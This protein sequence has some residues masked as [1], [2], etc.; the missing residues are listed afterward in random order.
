APY[1]TVQIQFA[2]LKTFINTSGSPNDYYLKV[3]SSAWPTHE[4]SIT[5]ATPTLTVSSANIVRGDTVTFTVEDAPGGTVS[6]WSY[7]VTDPV[8]WAPIARTTNVGDLT[9]TGPLAVSG[10]ANVTVA[11]GVHTAQLQ[12]H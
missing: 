5:V 9:W 2:P 7:Q 1:G 8:G 11:F 6:N 10:T 12:K 4:F 3:S